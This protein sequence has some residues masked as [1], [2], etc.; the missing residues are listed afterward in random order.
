[1]SYDPLQSWLSDLVHNTLITGPRVQ[2]FVTATLL[3][4]ISVA[5][6]T[7]PRAS[8]AV[9]KPSP[10][11]TSSFSIYT[12][13]S[14]PNATTN[15]FSSSSL[16]ASAWA[17]AELAKIAMELPLLLLLLVSVAIVGAQEAP[18]PAPAPLPES[19]CAGAAPDL[20]GLVL[21]AIASLLAAYAH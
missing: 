16:S 14:L 17:M 1:M 8:P 3:K 5:P 18:A 21:T 4:L 13:P 7:R 11:A 2:F 20:C 9:Q 6:A 19:G 10:T 15:S 12:S